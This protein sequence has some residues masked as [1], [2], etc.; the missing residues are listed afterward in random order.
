V[1]ETGRGELETAASHQNPLP[2]RRFQV[3]PELV[4]AADERNVFRG[5]RIGV[6]NDPRFTTMAPLVV[7]MLKLLEDQGL[8]AAFAERPR[9]GRSHRPS[10]KHDD[11]KVVRI[12]KL[13]SSGD[14][15]CHWDLAGYFG[16][17]GAWLPNTRAGPP[18]GAAQCTALAMTFRTSA[19]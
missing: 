17:R 5:L 15:I 14:A 12:Q 13:A 3:L 11:V 4:R 10:A 7:D 16:E 9:G 1:G 8:Q 18:A 2:A 6:T 19:L